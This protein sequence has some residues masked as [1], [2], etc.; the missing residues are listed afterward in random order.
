M[1]T[2]YV[3]FLALTRPAINR[4]GIPHKAFMMIFMITLL[5]GWWLGHGTGWHQL[6]YYTVFGPLFVGARLLTEWEH[7]AMRL[8]QLWF[9]TKAK[10]LGKRGG[11]LLS[12]M[13]AG[14]PS[15]ARDIAGAV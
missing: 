15:N 12:P 14:I 4:F 5:S 10:G 6:F 8:L 9:N 11:T 7:N 2:R 3:L 13:P 1:D